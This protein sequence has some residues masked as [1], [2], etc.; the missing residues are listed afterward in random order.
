MSGP[1]LALLAGP[2]LGS[3]LDD[4]WPDAVV[5]R[6]GL[7]APVDRL[8]DVH[9]VEEMLLHGDLGH[10]DVVMVVAP[11][12]RSP[13]TAAPTAVIGEVVVGLVQANRPADLADWLA[14]RRA[15]TQA[16]SDVAVCSMGKRLFVDVAESWL[17]GLGGAGWSVEDWG[18]RRISRVEL[19]TRLAQGPP[20]VVYA[21]H[22]RAR[23]WAGYQA[24]RWHHIDEVP[25]SRPCGV[26]IALAC[27]TLTRTRGVVAFGS[28][29]V[30][31]GRAA[32]Y[33]GWCGPLRIEPGMAIAD[34]MCR[35]FA[36]GSAVTAADMLRHV[37]RETIDPQ[38]QRELGWLRLIGDPLIPVRAAQHSS[39]LGPRS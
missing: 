11:R 20:M 9:R 32:A 4:A 27:D 31:S 19:C 2:H 5:T 14:A 36:G 3:A 39:A 18:A 15:R 23:G 34:R 28:R 1:T 21:G 16:R 25:V 38:E 7:P 17:D 29:W 33:I 26:V 8:R 13:R 12:N 10:P 22:G 35:V 24:L 37:A 30:A 6:H